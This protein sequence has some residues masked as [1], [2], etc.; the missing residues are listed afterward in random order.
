MLKREDQMSVNLQTALGG[1]KSKLLAL[2]ALSE[3]QLSQ[4]VEA[5]KHRDVQLAKEV[6]A[7]DTEVDRL[8]VELEEECLEV[9]A[10]H[11]PV[12][13]DLRFVVIV[14]KINNDLERIGDYAVNISERC[15]SLSEHSRS[16][17]AIDY[18]SLSDLVRKLLRESIQALIGQDV[19]LARKVW[20]A[21]REIDAMHRNNFEMIERRIK[22]SPDETH[23]LIQTL[24][25]SRYLERV[26]DLATNIAE[27]VVYLVEG[28]IIR[29]S[30]RG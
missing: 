17:M 22:A 2:A 18:S 25:V 21:D 12:A 9:L 16:D 5:L 6:I 24:S 7:R 23:Y 15:I 19:T 27:D 13:H 10:L 20:K 14:L 30:P 29:H 28:K 3:N 26:A 1:L 8:E 4:S 11:Q